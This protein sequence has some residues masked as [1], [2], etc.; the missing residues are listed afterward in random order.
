MVQSY[1]K[2]CSVPEPGNIADAAA[3]TTPTAASPPAPAPA[4][5]PKTFLV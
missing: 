1:C 2:D 4:P 3:T 5:A